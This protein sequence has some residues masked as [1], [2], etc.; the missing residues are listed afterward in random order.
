MDAAR[1]PDIAAACAAE[2][3]RIIFAALRTEQGGSR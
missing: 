3:K 1:L 2:A